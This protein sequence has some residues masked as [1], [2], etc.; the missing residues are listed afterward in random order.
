MKY[1]VDD[2]P[3]PAIIDRLAGSSILKMQN[4]NLFNIE[5]VVNEDENINE[6]APM[7]S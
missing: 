1:E 3:K 7:A 4:S 2:E 5:V 6:T